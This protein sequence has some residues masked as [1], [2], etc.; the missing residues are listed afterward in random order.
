MDVL[1]PILVDAPAAF[2]I[3][4]IIDA[5]TQETGALLSP[6]EKDGKKDDIRTVF[7]TV[8]KLGIQL[9]TSISIASKYSELMYAGTDNVDP[10]NGFL[11][12]SILLYSSPHFRKELGKLTETFQTYVKSTFLMTSSAAAGK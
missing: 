12:L 1:V 11:A 9:F 2:V 8:S 5:M 3:G 6:P 7:M 4:S 10:T